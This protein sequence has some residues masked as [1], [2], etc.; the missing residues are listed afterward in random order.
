M[1]LVFTNSDSPPLNWLSSFTVK[2]VGSRQN[3]LML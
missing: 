3:L 1:S 2:E